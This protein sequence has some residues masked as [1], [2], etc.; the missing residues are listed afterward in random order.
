MN[1]TCKPIRDEAYLSWVRQ[2]PCCVCFKPGPNDAHH[3]IGHGRMGTARVSDLETMPLC[4]EHH[5]ALHRLGWK[6]WEALHGDQRLVDRGIRPG[7]GGR[8][9]GGG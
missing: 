7:D 4:R 5:D 6:A 8:G 2:Q 3:R 1:W 9:R